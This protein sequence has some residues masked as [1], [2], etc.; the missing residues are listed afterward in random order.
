MKLNETRGR[1]SIKKKI[2]KNV[3]KERKRRKEN[4]GDYLRG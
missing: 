3:R 1:R 4:E 2:N